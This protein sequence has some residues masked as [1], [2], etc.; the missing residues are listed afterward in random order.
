MRG[1]FR[2]GTR[3]E[4]RCVELLIGPL[5]ATH[6]LSCLCW[7]WIVDAAFLCLFYW[8]RV[9]DLGIGGQG[10][11]YIAR[12]YNWSI[13]I[14]LLRWFIETL[15]KNWWFNMLRM[16][17]DNILFA[18]VRASI[19]L[20]KCCCILLLRTRDFHLIQA[21]QEILLILVFRAIVSSDCCPIRWF[22]FRVLPIHYRYLDIRAGG[23]GVRSLT[24][25]P[26]LIQL[27]HLLLVVRIY[28]NLIPSLWCRLAVRVRTRT[29]IR[30]ACEL[31]TC[32]LLQCQLLVFSRFLSHLSVRESHEAKTV[33]ERIG[34][35]I[36]ELNDFIVEAL[37]SL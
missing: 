36:V 16:L 30:A 19:F 11:C 8:W 20:Q 32:A 21:V 2:R 22:N 13:E 10:T 24:I 9:I 35:I 15:L 34:K 25:T 4:H 37:V 18:L 17:V 14:C 26:S 12:A 33:V 31:I 5:D 23:R 1:I 27:W 29:G 28:E 7:S 3:V 6:V